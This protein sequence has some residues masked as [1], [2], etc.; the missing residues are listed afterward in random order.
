[1]FS[2]G[3]V[4]LFSAVATVVTAVIVYKFATAVSTKRTQDLQSNYWGSYCEEK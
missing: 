4:L 3:E 2:I 1:M